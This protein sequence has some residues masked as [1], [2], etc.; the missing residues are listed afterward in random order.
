MVKSLRSKRV[1][2]R[3]RKTGGAA[4]NLV[5]SLMRVIPGRDDYGRMADLESDSIDNSESYE[6][7]LAFQKETAES[8]SAED[9]LR[10]KG[11]IELIA[12]GR[13]K[14]MDMESCVAFSSNMLF[15]DKKQ[16]LVIANE[17]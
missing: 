8:F 11:L 1:T 5:E 3:S 17:R 4:C 14:N 13:T 16:K 10:I 7:F 12:S 2:R 15:F 6:D 9:C